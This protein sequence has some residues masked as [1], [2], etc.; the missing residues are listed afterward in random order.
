[1]GDFSFSH[2]SSR[3]QLFEKSAKYEATAA[4]SAPVESEGVLLQVGLQML[5]GHGTLVGTKNPAFQQTGDSVYT[6]HGNVRR[7]FRRREY[8]LLVRVS[9]LGQPVVAFPAICENCRTGRYHVAN[10]GS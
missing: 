8:D 6:R 2:W 10:K 3:Y 9:A 4:R 7:V 5:F 1:M